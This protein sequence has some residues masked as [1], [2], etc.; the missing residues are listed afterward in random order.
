MARR[1]KQFCVIHRTGTP[2]D[3]TWHRSEPILTRETAQTMREGLEAQG[4]RAMVEDY[5]K[6]VSIGLPEGWE[7]GK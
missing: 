6:S 4:F 1:I 2:E 7:F 3:C 5:D